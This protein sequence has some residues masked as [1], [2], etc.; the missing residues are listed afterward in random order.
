MQAAL[1]DSKKSGGIERAAPAKEK[2]TPAYLVWGACIFFA[3]VY[4]A[5]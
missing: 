2:I 1:T 3:G 4:S 5:M